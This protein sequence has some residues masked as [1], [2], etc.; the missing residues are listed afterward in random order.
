MNFISLRKAQLRSFSGILVG[1]KSNRNRA[2]P[3]VWL[4]LQGPATTAAIPTLQNWT[5]GVSTRI[6]VDGAALADLGTEFLNS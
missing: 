3:E 5:A 4:S 2:E 6:Q 1:Q